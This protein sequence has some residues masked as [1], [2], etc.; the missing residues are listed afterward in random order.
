M[1]TVPRKQNNKQQ[2]KSLRAQ[3]AICEAAIKLLYEVG[4]GDTTLLKVAD[5]A[6]F[7]KGALQHHFPNKE[8]L[9][10]AAADKLLQ[11]SMPD[12]KGER[13]RRSGGRGGEI[14][15]SVEDALMY[16]WHKMVNTPE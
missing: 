13:G 14:A 3:D 6:G 12:R 8:D 4:Y 10:T 9:I 15:L 1:Q 5:I 7:S 16:S 11:R 2:E